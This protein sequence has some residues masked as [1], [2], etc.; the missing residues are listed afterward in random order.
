MRNVRLAEAFYRNEDVVGLARELLGK[1][2]CTRI[3]GEL[4]KA[5]INETEAY[6]GE[7]DRASHAFGGR[8]TRRTGV[9]YESGGHAYVY[10]CYGIHY[11]FNIVTNEADVPHA[12]L[13][14]GALPFEGRRTM[15]RRRAR[16]DGDL[17]LMNGP[18]KVAQGMGITTTH[19][20]VSLQSRTIWLEQCVARVPRGE[21]ICGPRVG[22]DYAGADAA[23]PYRFRLSKA[24]SSVLTSRVRV[25]T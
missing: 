1:L 21:I 22:V 25:D 9:M 20:G 8:R 24:F 3:D 2:L 14:R 23:L 7:N 10:L 19:S 16:N 17:D 4:C 6:A 12:V 18:G 15:R 11:L 5:I 13:V